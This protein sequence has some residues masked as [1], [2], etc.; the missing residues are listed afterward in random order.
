MDFWLRNKNYFTISIQLNTVC[1]SLCVYTYMYVL[2]LVA[3]LNP[4]L[5]D[6]MDYIPPD[7]SVHAESLGKNTGVGVCV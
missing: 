7:S 1:P 5:C 6:P 2:C 4:T 3:Q